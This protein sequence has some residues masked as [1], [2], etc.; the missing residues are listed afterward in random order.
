MS[1]VD[2]TV[3]INYINLARNESS[4]IGDMLAGIYSNIL[5]SINKRWRKMKEKQ[6][7]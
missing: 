7:D 6:K 4:R 2:K 5:C 3:N 1:N